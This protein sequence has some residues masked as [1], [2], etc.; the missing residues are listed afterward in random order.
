MAQYKIDWSISA[1]LDLYDILEFYI[2][3]NGTNTYSKKLNSRINKSAKLI[4]K[5]P[6][7]GLKTDF[8]TV[9]VL[10]TE[11]FE[12]IYEIFDQLILII[13]VW[14]CK[15]DPDEKDLKGRII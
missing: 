4:S 11:D 8:K 2:K 9:R 10:I 5:N 15:K 7:L 1:K 12:I 13:M 3:R 14:D 6:Y